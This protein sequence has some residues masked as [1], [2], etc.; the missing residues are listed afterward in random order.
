MR[1]GAPPEGPGPEILVSLLM[2]GDSRRRATVRRG[3]ALLAVEQNAQRRDG[4]RGESDHQVPALLA[5][6]L[7]V[8]SHWMFHRCGR[9]GTLESVRRP[10]SE[11]RTRER[12][13]TIF[14]QHDGG[15]RRG[16]GNR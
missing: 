3:P 9:G 7:A 1:T 5:G 11:L 16:R 6:E 2:R 4:D 15:G 12:L 13:A 8:L 10:T 14:R